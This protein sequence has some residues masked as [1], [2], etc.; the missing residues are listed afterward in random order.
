[1]LPV[2]ETN[3]ALFTLILMLILVF[4]GQMV[5]LFFLAKDLF[6]RK[7]KEEHALQDSQVHSKSILSRAIRQANKIVTTAQLEGMQMMSEEKSTGELLS[8]QFEERLKNIEDTLKVQ[9]EKSAQESEDLFL[10][11]IQ[12]SQSTLQGDIAK[13]NKLLEQ[14]AQQYIEISQQKL[15]ALM[16]ELQS[17]IKTEVDMQF[18][19]AKKE[20]NEYKLHRIA[21]ID[22]KIIDILDEVLKK[23]LGAGLSIDAQSTLVYKALEEAKKEHAFT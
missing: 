6:E 1:M 12:N 22:E 8:Q 17:R 18:A 4:A 20:V 23:A 15:D 2:L 16:T 21:I 19:E 10:Q 14:K 5:I 7:M 9:F 13:N 3:S 11:F